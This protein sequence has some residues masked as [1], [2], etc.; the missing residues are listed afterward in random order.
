MS[1]GSL[2]APWRDEA[3]CVTSIKKDP[4]LASAWIQENHVAQDE[5]VE[6]CEACPVIWACVQN[7]LLDEEA[8]GLRG[9]YWFDEGKLPVA[10]AREIRDRFPGIKFGEWQSMGRPKKA[11]SA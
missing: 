9:G 3:K 8:N 5:A 7:A 1:A 4:T 10:K 2:F 11:K 6:I